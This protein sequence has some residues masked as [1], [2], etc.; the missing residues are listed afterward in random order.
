MCISW[1]QWQFDT[2]ASCCVKLVISEQ[3]FIWAYLVE[4]EFFFGHGQQA[5]MN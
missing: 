5:G 1:L 3:L 4:I 2:R